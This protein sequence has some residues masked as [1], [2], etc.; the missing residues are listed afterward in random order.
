M[1]D[2]PRVFL[3]E[4]FIELNHNTVNPVVI[5]C[6]HLKPYLV[7]KLED[8]NIVFYNKYPIDI[9]NVNG[10][11]NKYPD[12]K[13]FCIWITDETRS[14]STPKDMFIF[15]TS[16][17]K[18]TSGTGED[19]FGWCSPIF[20][21]ETFY[22]ITNKPFDPIYKE[23]SVGFCGA[24]T[25][26]CQKERWECLEHFRKSG[27]KC[28]YIQRGKFIRG[29]S[30]PDQ[31][32]FRKVD[33]IEN[34]KNNIFAIAPRGGGNWSLRFYEAMAYGRIPVLINTDVILP[35]CEIIDWKNVV[36]FADT[37]EELEQIVRDWYDRGEEFIKEKQKTCRQIWEKHLS[38]EGFVETALSKIMK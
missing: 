19:G 25:K 6:H 11:K 21:K 32:K 12:K 7:S 5:I 4:K 1:I 28:D 14:V 35:F 30:Q 15:R 37:N 29:F 17:Y 3:S 22:S 16:G 10:F 8:A 2:K 26:S 18:K 23:L 33:F 13:R 31:E 38:M 36:V 27:I 34:M 24:G 20:F 9:N